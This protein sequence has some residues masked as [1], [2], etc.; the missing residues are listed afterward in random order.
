M[1]NR[2][3]RGISMASVGFHEPI[4]H[5]GSVALT[6]RAPKIERNACCITSDSPQ[7]ASR[8]SSGRW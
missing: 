4:S 1:T 7:V 5:S 2:P 3:L 6:S 8:V